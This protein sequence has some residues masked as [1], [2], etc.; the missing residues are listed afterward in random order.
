MFWTIPISAALIAVVRPSIDTVE[1]KM[2]NSGF[3]VWLAGVSLSKG[4]K[5]QI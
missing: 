3:Y 2:K 4:L 5:N 1:Q